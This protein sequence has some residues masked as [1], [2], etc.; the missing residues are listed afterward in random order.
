MPPVPEVQLGERVFDANCSQ[1]HPGGT[2]GLGP[3]INN[4]PLPGWLIEFQIRHG[5]GAMPAFS[6]EEVSDEEMDAVVKYLKWLR[7]LERR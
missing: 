1:C 6:S 2:G 4:K 3:A 7:G 5:L